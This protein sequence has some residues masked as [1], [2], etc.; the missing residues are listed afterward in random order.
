MV[1]SHLSHLI[2][3]L[4]FFELTGGL[5]KLRSGQVFKMQ[6]Q[7]SLRPG[8]PDAATIYFVSALLIMLKKSDFVHVLAQTH[9][10]LLTNISKFII[11]I[12]Y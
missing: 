8:Y 9:E 11:I 6:A 3:S 2:F 1:S 10:I 12:I 7:G 5:D 4:L